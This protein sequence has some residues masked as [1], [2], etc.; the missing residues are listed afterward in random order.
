MATQN[1]VPLSENFEELVAR[2]AGRAVDD[3]SLDFDVIIVGSGY[4]GAIAAAELSGRLE[5]GGRVCVLERGQAYAPGDFPSTLAELPTHVRANGGRGAD[6]WSNREGLFDLRLGMDISTIVANGLGGGSL[7]N[8]GV[9]E[10]P[11]REVFAAGWPD[12]IKN[13]KKLYEYFA[14]TAELFGAVRGEKP[15]TIL[16]HRA[17]VP[18]KYE[19]LKRLA[20]STPEHPAVFREAKVTVAMQDGPNQADLTLDACKRCGDCATGCNHN[21][22]NSL[23]RNLLVQAR[24]RGAEIFTGAA[25]LRVRPV[26]YKNDET[27]QRGNG[28]ELDVAYTSEKL[29]LSQKHPITLRCRRVILAAGTIGST[30]ILLRSASADLQFSKCLGRGFSANGDMTAVGYAQNGKVNAIADESEAPHEREV[31]P[32]ITGIIEAHD[33]KT[34]ERLVIEELAVP[35]PLKTLFQELYTT[36]ELLHKLGEPDESEHTDGPLDIDPAGVNSVDM[37]RTALYAIMGDDG[38]AGAIQL[39]EPKTPPASD[40]QGRTEATQHQT[41]QNESDARHTAWEGS[42]FVSWPDLP[43]HA[44]FKRQMAAMKRLIKESRIGGRLIANPLW[45]FLPDSM[46]FLLDERRGTLLTV[47]PLGG[48]RMGVDSDS[49][50][51]DHFGRVFDPTS[52]KGSKR[53]EGLFVLDGSIIPTALRT[54][55]ALTIAA[56]A[57][58][59]LRDPDND[60]GWGL[61]RE[62]APDQRTVQPVRAVEFESDPAPRPQPTEIEIVERMSGTIDVDLGHGETGS[63]VVELTLRFNQKAIKDLIAGDGDSKSRVLRVNAEQN[64]RLIESQIRIFKPDDWQKVIVEDYQEPRL[65]KKL[66]AAAEF[67]APVSGYL[68]VFAQENSSLWQR[69]WRSLWAWFANRGLRDIWQAIYER[70]AR[71][72]P[73]A[74]GGFNFRDVPDRARHLWTLVTHT[75]GV[76][77]LEYH[78]KIGP[79]S[80]RSIVPGL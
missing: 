38:A 60:N 5:G 58:R 46:K 55:P 59:A 51:V 54:N 10:I 40:D 8:A 39:D 32:T 68:N 25:V 76:R 1:K 19:A 37:D 47:H 16:D 61:N 30:E 34:A 69:R 79:A 20:H 18:K 22:K 33:S 6:T 41:T 80:K 2:R 29:R 72:S 49:G 75:G 9:M 45:Q 74:T 64:K 3:R 66:D 21:A 11:E 48:C 71:P 28:W 78:L 17:G 43:K 27:D 24:R 26:P 73:G 52:A 56:M 23:D 62:Q 53:H 63:R 67:I 31:G 77:M 57:L 70:I 12:A 36:A 65:E 13:D 42:A 15:N 35:G 14:D 44:L 7:I 50:V 4:G